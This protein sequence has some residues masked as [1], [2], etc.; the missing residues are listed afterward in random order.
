MLWF[1]PLV[2]VDENAYAVLLNNFA[3]SRSQGRNADFSLMWIWFRIAAMI[4]DGSPP[5][6]V[7]QVQ[8]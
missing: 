2:R 8:R 6:C 5:L 7:R 3:K 4:G 1:R